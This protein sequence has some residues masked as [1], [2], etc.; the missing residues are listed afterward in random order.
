MARLV[1]RGECVVLG[2]LFLVVGL[3]GF[4]VGMRDGTRYRRAVLPDPVLLGTSI[5]G[6]LGSVVNLVAAVAAFL[7]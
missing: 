6:F 3:V 4:G 2:W 1:A 5:L 7:S